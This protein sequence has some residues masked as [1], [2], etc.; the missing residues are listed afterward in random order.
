MSNR[1]HRNTFPSV[2]FVYQGTDIF[3]KMSEHFHKFWNS[4]VFMS[5]RSHHNAILVYFF[6]NKLKFSS[7]C[8][9]IFIHSETVWFLWATDHTIVHNTFPA[10]YFVN[11][12]SIIFFHRD[13]F[14]HIRFFFLSYH[15]P[16]ML[17]RH[18]WWQFMWAKF[19][20]RNQ[21]ILKEGI[22]C[23]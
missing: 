9:H 13:S 12:W 3:S 10:V 20:F 8:L 17:S 16:S 23:K 14:D 1:S 6:M 7:I 22:W 21:W 15:N 19:S 4:L 18:L 2:H 5:N 11:E